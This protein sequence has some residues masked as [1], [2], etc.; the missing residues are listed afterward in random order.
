MQFSRCLARV[1]PYTAADFAKK[2]FES[3]ILRLTVTRSPVY[4][5]Q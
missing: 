1:F 3:C 4:N 5:P 2:G